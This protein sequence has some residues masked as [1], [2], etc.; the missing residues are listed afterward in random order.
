M[1]AGLALPAAG[2]E[3]F[4]KPAGPRKA[5]AEDL[6]RNQVCFDAEMVDSIQLSV[7]QR[8]IAEKQYFLQSG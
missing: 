3:T 7:S 4:L 5:V 8:S 1:I 6:P 2:A